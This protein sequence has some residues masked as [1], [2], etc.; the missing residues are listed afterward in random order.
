MHTY[1][2]RDDIKHGEE[3]IN[4]DAPKLQQVLKPKISVTWY[5]GKV[6]GPTKTWYTNGIQ[7]SQKEMSNNKKNGH[8]TAWYNDG[9]LM[10]IEEYEQ[11]KLVR[12]E[13]YAKGEKFPVSMIIDGKGIVTR[14]DADGTFLQRIT[15]KSGKPQLDE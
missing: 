9:S 15:Y 5:D 7:E 2:V 14:F 6:Q 4:Y 12:G 8:S 1:V 3:V 11:D 13:Y 10:M